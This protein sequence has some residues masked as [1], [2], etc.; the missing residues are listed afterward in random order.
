M[1]STEVQEK[2][3]SPPLSPKNLFSQVTNLLV[4]I[5]QHHSF[6]INPCEGWVKG[7]RHL[8]F[9]CLPQMGEEHGKMWKEARCAM[10]MRSGVVRDRHF[11]H[12]AKRIY[13]WCCPVQSQELDSLW[14]PSTSGYSVI[15]KLSSLVFSVVPHEEW[16]LLATFRL[17]KLFWLHCDMCDTYEI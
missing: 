5:T 12:R 14:I 6:P 10:A 1:G 13:F 16:V 3:A 9:P 7:E 15:L 4:V 11:H 17:K 8:P 2:E